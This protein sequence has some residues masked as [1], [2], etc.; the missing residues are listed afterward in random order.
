MGA[1]IHADDLRTS[2]ASMDCVYQQ[3]NIIK[4][5]SSDTCFELNACKCEAVWICPP[6]QEQSVL[7]VGDSHISI[8]EAAKCLGVWWNSSLS[9]RHSVTE[10][11]GKARKALGRLGA[12]QG[13]LNPFSSCSIFETCVIPT[14]LYGCET[15][16]LRLHLSYSTK[17]GVTSSLY[18]NSNQSWLFALVLTGLQSLPEHDQKIR[19]LKQTTLIKQGHHQKSSV[20]LSCN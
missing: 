14:L 6:T 13:D 9:A 4:S 3:D 7:Q 16:L 5:F 20:Y 18:P 11:I 2:A 10:N 17:S 12:F 19:F 15:W 8:S 1:A